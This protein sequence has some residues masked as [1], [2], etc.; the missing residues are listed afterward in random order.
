MMKTEYVLGH[1]SGG[2]H[3][4][5]VHVWG[6]ANKSSVPLICVHGLLRNGRDFDFLAQKLSSDRQVFCPDIVGRGLSDDLA[7]PLDYSFAQYMADITALIAHIGADQVDWV[8][9]SMGGLLGMMVAAQPKTPIRR[10]VINDVGPV[11]P[12]EEMNRIGEYLINNYPHFNSVA[13]IEERVRKVYAQFGALTGAQWRHIAE[14]NYRNTPEGD[15]VLAY[16]PELAQAFQAMD[17]DFDF[18]NVYDQVS[19]PTL[20]TRGGM[21]D[22]LPQSVAEEMTKRGPKARLVVIDNVGHMPVFMNGEQTKLIE[23]FLNG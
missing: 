17:K 11:V 16:D 22:L 10:L 12:R 23:D 2:F 6:G 18:W 15:L 3:K 4:M 1:S 13:E 21:S 20:I 19:C 5:A 8:G 9:S 7:N 14:H